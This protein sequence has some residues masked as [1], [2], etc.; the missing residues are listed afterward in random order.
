MMRVCGAHAPADCV[1]GCSS[2]DGTG[3]PDWCE[4]DWLPTDPRHDFYKCAWRP[5]DTRQMLLYDAAN[6]QA[7]YNEV[8]L[9][10]AMWTR[11]MPSTIEAFV[12]ERDAWGRRP[13]QV[14]ACR[15]LRDFRAAFPARA[16]D[17]QLMSY[18]GRRKHQGQ[19]FTQEAC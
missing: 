18:D 1:P 19:P 6:R 11:H 9:D 7:H 12:F 17:V 3:A 10:A 14:D 16:K 15:A 5:S 2:Q 8:V 4:P 13:E